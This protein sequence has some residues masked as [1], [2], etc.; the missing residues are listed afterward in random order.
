M[1]FLG[2]DFREQTPGSDKPNCTYCQIIQENL[3]MLEICRESD[4]FHCHLAEED[5][6]IQYYRCHAGL[7][8]AIFPLFS[9]GRCIGFIMIGQFRSTSGIPKSIIK[10]AGDNISEMQRAY[11]SLDEYYPD[12]LTS[13]L[14]LIRITTQYIIEN[15]ILEEKSNPVTEEIINFIDQNFTLNPKVQDVANKVKRSVNMVNKLLKSTTGL[16]FKQYSIKLRMNY[17][18]DLLRN[19]P[20]MNIQEVSTTVGIED[21]FYFSR[22]FKNR[23][24]ISPKE[25]KRYH[26][27][28]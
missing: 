27:E 9:S 16:S 12:K 15:R 18:A 7:E 6:E 22:L 10:K 26:Q 21:Q 5:R 13:I 11:E 2:P 20:E 25:Y 4:I 3:G 19:H 24:G 8:E 1:S 28:N 17:G 14:E 23:F